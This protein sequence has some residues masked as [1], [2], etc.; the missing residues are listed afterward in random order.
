MKDTSILEVD[1][2]NDYAPIPEVSEGELTVWEPVLILTETGRV[3]GHILGLSQDYLG[4]D[5]TLSGKLLSWTVVTDIIVDHGES[6]TPI[7]TLSGKLIGV[8]SAV[9]TLGKRSYGVR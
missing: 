5:A 4:Y 1:L 3:Q 7:W 6:G 9:D 2:G 8:M